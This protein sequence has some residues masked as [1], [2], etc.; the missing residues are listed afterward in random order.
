MGENDNTLTLW[1]TEPCIRKTTL[2]RTLDKAVIG[3]EENIKCLA[4]SDEEKMVCFA[5]KKQLSI[6][7]ID[8]LEELLPTHNLASVSSLE[9]SLSRNLFQFS[10]INFIT[11]VFINKHEQLYIIAK[12]NEE[13]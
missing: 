9:A 13:F 5:R 6:T 7:F 8:S 4:I 12:I 10:D 3:F 1:D 2:S 11:K